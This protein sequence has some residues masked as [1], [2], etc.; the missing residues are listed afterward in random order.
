MTVPGGYCTV[1][2][3]ECSAD[4]FAPG[5]CPTGAWC[6]NGIQFGEQAGDFCMKICAGG[7]DCREGEGYKCCPW[8]DAGVCY[9]GQGCP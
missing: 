1:T 4:P 6:V 2:I 9:Y 7:A 3:A 5:F 8:G